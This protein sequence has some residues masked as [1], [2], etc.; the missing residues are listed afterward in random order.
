MDAVEAS[1]A[2][3]DET[4]EGLSDELTNTQLGL[5]EAYELAGGGN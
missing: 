4:I 3:Q 2:I 1:Q 5:A